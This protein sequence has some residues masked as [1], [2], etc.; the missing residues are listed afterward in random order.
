LPH[1]KELLIDVARAHSQRSWG[2]ALFVYDKNL[3]ADAAEKVR[4]RIERFRQELEQIERDVLTRLLQ[5]DLIHERELRVALKDR[6]SY[7]L[8]SLFLMELNAQENPT[9]HNSP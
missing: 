2:P 7:L 1:Q 8:P 9:V 5:L 6:P 3:P 4:Q